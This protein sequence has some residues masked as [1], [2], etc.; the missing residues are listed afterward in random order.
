[1]DFKNILEKATKIWKEVIWDFSHKVDVLTAFDYIKQ[2]KNIALVGHDKIDGDSLGSTLALKHWLENKFPDKKI[3][4]YTNRKYPKVFEFL[5][6]DILY[7]EGLKL[8]EDTDLIITLDAANLNRLGEFYETNKEKFKTTTIINIDHHISNSNFWTINLVDGTS[9]ATAQFLYEIL[10]FLDNNLNNLVWWWLK[11]GL[12]QIVATYLLLGILTDTQV[13]M[14]PLANDKTLKIAAELIELWADK[15]L[16]INKI[17]LSKSLWELKLQWL[18]LDRISVLEYNG[19]K[20]YWSYYSN[21]DLLS[22]GLDVEDPGLGRALPSIL[23]QIEDADFIALWKIKDKETS[24]SFRSK[25]FD[26][27]QLASKLWWGGHKNA[28]W[29]KLDKKLTTEGISALMKKI[30]ED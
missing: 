9:P 29:A 30:V 3:T 16:L 15:Q 23:M 27:N 28:A 14:I 18:V 10:K 21:E 12:D 26:V 20:A 22:L 19:I 6:P 1:M 7:W 24:V 25:E 17:F 8:D 5:N 11:K 2:A 13:F 4:A